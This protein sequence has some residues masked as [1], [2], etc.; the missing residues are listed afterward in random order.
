MLRPPTAKKIIRFAVNAKM[1]YSG[2]AVS[3]TSAPRLEDTASTSRGWPTT[4][5]SRLRCVSTAPLETPVVP[6]VYCSA[7]MLSWRQRRCDS[8]RGLAPRGDASHAPWRSASG[9]VTCCEGDRRDHLLHVLLHRA[10]DEPLERRQQVGDADEDDRADRGLRQDLGDLVG[11]DVDGDQADGAAVGKLVRHL[12]G[13]VE[14]V[15]VHH[16]E[17][18]LQA[19]EHRNRIRQT[20]GHLQRDAIAGANPATSRRYTANSIGAADRPRRR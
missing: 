15:G 7:A 2:S 12:R 14:R 18:G 19:A 8:A 16:H 13:G 11:E 17:P 3:I 1:W 9:N 5:A 6:P 20:V 4:F 10:D